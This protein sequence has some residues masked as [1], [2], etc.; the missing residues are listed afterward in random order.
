VGDEAQ[1]LHHAARH[2]DVYLSLCAVVA[3]AAASG[4]LAHR[5]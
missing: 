5:L 2:D 1:L 4:G 3:I